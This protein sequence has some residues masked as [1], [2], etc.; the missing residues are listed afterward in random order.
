MTRSLDKQVTKHIMKGNNSNYSKRKDYLY[1]QRWNK[2][3]SKKKSSEMRLH[4]TYFSAEMCGCCS[5]QH[6]TIF[7]DCLNE[8]TELSKDLER[9]ASTFRTMTG[10]NTPNILCIPEKNYVFNNIILKQ[11]Q[12]ELQ[13][14]HRLHHYHLQYSTNLMSWN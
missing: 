3:A 6:P 10:F 9:R 2:K 11:H 14:L 5:S 7:N 13:M 12:Y 1:H 8:P 4:E